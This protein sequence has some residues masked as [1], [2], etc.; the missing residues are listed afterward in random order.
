MPGTNP[1]LHL[2][3][4]LA[5]PPFPSQYYT[6]PSVTEHNA[7]YVA[8]S[9]LHLAVLVCQ[10]VKVHS[11]ANSRDTGFGAPKTPGELGVALQRIGRLKAKW[12][13]SASAVA[14]AISTLTR[15]QE[16]RFR[17]CDVD[18]SERKILGS[19]VNIGLAITQDHFREL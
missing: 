18:L 12:I 6:S 1:P 19:S 13:I 3:S 17:D 5:M 9:F 11:H 14:S 16:V 2:L 4:F 7:L 10:T 15:A 8:D